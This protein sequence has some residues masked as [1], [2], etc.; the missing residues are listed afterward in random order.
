MKRSIFLLAALL[1]FSSVL[2]KAQD[3]FYTKTGKI[4]F[5]APT[6]A[7][8]I[9]AVNKSVVVLMNTKTGDVQF[10]VLMKGFEFK[11]AL[12]QEHF[13]IQSVESDKFPQADFKGQIVDNNIIDYGKD[14][15]YNVKVKGKLTIHG[16]T[17]DI[18]ATGTLSVKNGKININSVFNILLSDYKVRGTDVVP[19]SFKIT[20]DCALDPLKQ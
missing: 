6:N 3:K 16:E 2:V 4:S 1:I 20:V 12:M 10:A 7:E 18:D 14:G 17:K 5:F 15:A 8:N 19:N 11:K 13:N 9:E